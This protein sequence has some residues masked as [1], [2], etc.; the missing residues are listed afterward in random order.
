MHFEWDEEK[1]RANAAKHGIDFL[2]VQGVFDGRPRVDAASPRRGEERFST[3]A[4][5]EGRFVAV[6]W[7]WRGEGVVR[8]VSAGRARVGEEWAHRQLHG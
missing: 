5:L 3:T 2:D 4:R 8:I 1:R 7:T 6:V